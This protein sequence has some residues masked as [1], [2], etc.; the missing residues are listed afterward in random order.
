[1]L[2]EV[3]MEALSDLD[4]LAY[5]FDLP[6]ELIAERPA[7]KR[8]HSRLLV[9]RARSKQI[10]H[11]Q[12]YEL[13]K[14]LNQNDNLVLN[15]SR[16][17]PCRLFGQ[18]PTEGKV[19]LFILSLVAQDDLFPVMLKC[20]GRKKVGDSYQFGEL[21]ATLEKIDN[22]GGFWVKFNFE[23]AKLYDF[24][25]QNA[26]IPIP[27]YIRN[28]LSDE[29][30]KQDYQTIFANT[31]GSVAAPTAGLHFTQDLFERLAFKQINPYYLTLHVGAGTFSPVSTDDISQH[32]MH[33][34]YFEI[35]QPVLAHIEKNMDQ[36]IVVGTTSFR[37]LASLYQQGRFHYPNGGQSQTDIFIY[38][39]SRKPDNPLPK[40]KAMITNF[41]L[42]QSSLIMLISALIGRENV[43]AI[44]Q[45]A[46][47]HKYR[48]YSY[49]DAMLILFNE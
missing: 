14:L 20:S 28:G 39:G 38:P 47:E 37:V 44:Y 24:L 15:Q 27:P 23:L 9:Y 2:I 5:A 30:D 36:T 3:A 19:E 49:G 32:H 31:L 26:L 25:E 1:M 18:K 40:F 13:D 11:H 16:V 42:P 6:R 45:T 17:F 34:E 8:D 29:K 4:K 41:H 33:S 7:L 21:K 22:Q 43:L 12:F 10:S 46:I 35:T 48:F